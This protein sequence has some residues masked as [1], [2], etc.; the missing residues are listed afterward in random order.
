VPLRELR[1]TLVREQ[2]WRRLIADVRAVSQGRL[3]Y[4]ADWWKEFE[5]SLQ[6]RAR[7]RRCPGPLPLSEAQRRRVDELGAG[8]AV[9]RD[10][11][12]P[13]FDLQAAAYE[14]FFR[15]FWDQPWFAGSYFWKWYP[16]RIENA[17]NKAPS[18][19]TSRSKAN[20]PSPSSGGGTP[21]N[22][23]PMVA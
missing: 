15:V 1:G 13:D 20:P 17:T 19:S 10:V 6:G 8:W 5:E 7:L 14:A 11:S 2:G 23:P 12:P 22:H 9:H 4:A 18:A 3:K 16:G 21:H